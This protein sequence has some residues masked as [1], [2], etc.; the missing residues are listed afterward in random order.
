MKKRIV[1]LALPLLFASC[2]KGKNADLVIYNA[3][4]HTM[5]KDGTIAQAMAVRDGKIL[6]TGPER[7]ILNKYS[8]ETEIDAQKREV[9]PGFTD[10]HGHMLLY[11]AQKLMADLSGSL[12]YNEMIA[13][14]EKFH[15]RSNKTVIV[16]RGWDQSL[17]KSAELPDNQK[18]NEVFPEIPVY[19]ERVDGHAALVNNAM[20]RKAGIDSTTRV[21]GG[22]IQLRNGQCTGLLL[23][24][25]VGLVKKFLPQPSEKELT[26]ALLEVQD[27][28][29]MYGITGV[30]EAGIERKHIDLFK[31]M[32]TAG[33]L[34][35][36]LYA[37]LMPSEEN[38]AFARKE[39]IYQYKNLS[40][41]SFKVFADGALGS[42]GALLKKVYSDEPG[43]RGLLL[44]PMNQMEDIAALCNEIGYQMN[45]HAI[46]D[47]ANRIILELYAS[48]FEKNPDHRWRIEHAQI[49]S[50]EDLHYFG[51][52]SIFPSVQP[53]H[54]TSDQRW[55][56]ARLGK[57]RL[58]GAYAYRS[59]KEQYGMI[60]FGTDFPIEQI[61]PFRTI[62]AA[63]NRKNQ[64]NEP[65]YGFLPG[66]AVSLETCLNAM[67]IWPAFAA[68]SETRNGSLEAGK[69]ATF[70]V[71]DK[72]IRVSP[73]YQENYAFYTYIRGEQVYSAE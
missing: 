30:H 10:A 16:G 20:L 71:L 57:Q 9:Y 56:E 64:Q 17:W 72:P 67:T 66:E 38:I 61:D 63:T 68:F 52:Y 3:Q 31:K 6:E 35:I 1:L 60:A 69:D 27:E 58:Q 28:L 24:N 45:T 12:S 46:G 11:A 39:G 32:I 15:S 5:D 65:S 62:H 47:S 40:I 44:T 70:I 41:R 2:F 54:A 26:D 48:A 4:I 53:T 55:A 37:M 22:L 13:R 51:D 19:L 36:D 8:A 7:Q 21:E 23:D 73:V 59:L 18:L 34:K 43:H 42:R 29:L 25:A 49:I 50:P 14:V 33:K